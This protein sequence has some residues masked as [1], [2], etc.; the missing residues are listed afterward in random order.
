MHW[1]HAISTDLVH[2]KELPVGIYPLKYGMGVWSGSAIMDYHNTT[3]LKKGEDAVMI[4]AYT[5]GGRGE[6]IEFSNDKGRTFT[7]Y[8][9]NPVVKHQGRDPK[10]IWFES[11]KHWVMAVYHEEEGKRWIAFYT[12]GDLKDWT[13]QSKIEGFYEC[14]EIFELQVDGSKQSKSK[15]VLYA[16]DGAY[17]IGSFNGKE[18]ITEDGRF[19]NNFGNCF[20]ASQI[21]NNIPSEDG[22]RI[23]IAWGRVTTPGM[24]FNQCMLFP[25]QLTLRKM[26]EGVRLFT[27]PVKEI[28]LLHKKEWK[29]EN[30][31]IEAGNNPINEVTGE[32]YHIKGDFRP[33]TKS[34]IGFKIH[35]TEVLY[36]AAS[37]ELACM[38]KKAKAGL[39][40]DKLYLEIIV[41]RNTIEIFVNHGRVYMPIS[42]DL[43]KDYGLELICRNESVVAERLQIFELNSI[44]Q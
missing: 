24:P 6:V 20:Y 18:F 14:P 32:L 13:Y 30:L 38:D 34:Q 43:T 26:E 28:E 25:T 21:F 35:G 10:L 17:V 15:W 41:D 40:G 39:E 27:E 2:W 36:D 12:S 11:G 23:Q 44:W 16:A 37:G 4:A 29:K 33:G 42:R 19:P 9:K 5:S 31:A 8:E 7:W 1:G 22:R 3:G